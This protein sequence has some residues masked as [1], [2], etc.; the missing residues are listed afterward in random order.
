MSQQFSQRAGGN[1][2][3]GFMKTALA[4]NQGELVIPA[5]ITG[6]FSHPIFAPDVQQV[7][8]MKLKGLLPSGSNPASLTNTLQSVLGGAKNQPPGQQ[9][10]SP[11]Q[12]QQIQNPA[13]QILECSARRSRQL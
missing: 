6:T 9:S 12:Q 13:G 11:G 1:N 3:G 7:A 5:T 2:V 8:Q 4:N 10:Q